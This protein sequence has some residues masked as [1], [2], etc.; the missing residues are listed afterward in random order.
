MI[1]HGQSSKDYSPQ[2]SCSMG[3]SWTADGSTDVTSKSTPQSEQTI[4]SPASVPAS[5]ATSASHS[6][7]TTVDMIYSPLVF[8]RFCTTH[9]TFE[10]DCNLDFYFMLG[11]FHG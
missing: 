2:S 11:D 6:G 8:Y 3:A 1:I 4:I 5:N 7:H 10:I 9:Q